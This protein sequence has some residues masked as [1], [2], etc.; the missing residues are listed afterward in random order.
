MAVLAAA[1]FGSAMKSEGQEAPYLSTSIGYGGVYM[2]NGVEQSFVNTTRVKE[3]A[4]GVLSDSASFAP[5][6]KACHTYSRF[7]YLRASSG[8][9]ERQTAGGGLYMNSGGNM[10]VSF[11]DEI[12]IRGK[13]NTPL[14]DFV[15]Y[16]ENWRVSGMISYHDDGS[17]TGGAASYTWQCYGVGFGAGIGGISKHPYREEIDFMGTQ[18]QQLVTIENASWY[19]GQPFGLSA[20]LDVMS[21]A[22]GI[23]G[24]ASE[25]EADA[26]VTLELL[27]IEVLDPETG[28]LLPVTITAKSGHRY[29]VVQPPVQGVEFGITSLVTDRD[30]GSVFLSFSSQSA[31]NY[32]V[33][34]GSDLGN[35]RDWQELAVVPGNPGVTPV[36]F[37]DPEAITQGVR[38]YVVE[39][40]ED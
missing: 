40:L 3:S 2:L 25:S 27:S 32:R 35:V 17:A 23:S 30:T 34:G 1:Y 36:N 7:G 38:F 18:P 5:T 12:T 11:M 22:G 24:E 21:S 15:H 39:K 28:D 29:P 10:Q 14:P 19:S 8:A 26:T 31:G 6:G 16:R 37:N 20:T 33:K 13:G 9:L 4:N